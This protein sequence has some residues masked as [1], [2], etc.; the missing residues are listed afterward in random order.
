MGI[1]HGIGSLDDARQ[2]GH[3]GG[4]FE[5]LLIHFV[6][7]FTTGIDDRRH[8]HPACGWDLPDILAALDWL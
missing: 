2:A 4:L 5:D 1:G 7:E 8:P 3:V 6:D